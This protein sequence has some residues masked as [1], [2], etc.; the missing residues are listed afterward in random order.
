MKDL[1]E[2]LKELRLPGIT[3]TLPSRLTQAREQAL[4][5]QDWLGLLLQDELERRHRQGLC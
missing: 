4:P 5:H 3:E 2:Q 1:Y